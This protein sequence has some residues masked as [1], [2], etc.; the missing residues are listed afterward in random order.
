M[1]SVFLG[2]REDT[3]PRTHIHTELGW[4]SNDTYVKSDDGADQV[5]KRPFVWKKCL[6]DF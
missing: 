5:G 1:V 4:E 6:N 2:V 3:P